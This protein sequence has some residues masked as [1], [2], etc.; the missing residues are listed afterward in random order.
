MKWRLIILSLCF[1][2]IYSVL[3]NANDNNRISP[4]GL[5]PSTVNFYI[6]TSIIKK[7]IKSTAFFIQNFIFK[8]DSHRIHQWVNWFKKQTDCDT[9]DPKSLSK[10]GIDINQSLYIAYENP[11]NKSEKLIIFIPV[12]NEK[13]F[14][15]NFIKMLKKINKDKTD[16]DLNPITTWYKDYKTNQILKDIFF[17]TIDGYFILTSSS[18][19]MRQII[20]IKKDREGDSLLESP[21]YCDY[22]KQNNSP[23]D[24][25]LFIKKEFFIN[26]YINTLKLEK[27]RIDINIVLSEME[28]SYFDLIKYIGCGLKI[29]SGTIDFKVLASINLDCL[30]AKLLMKIFIP[31]KLEKSIFVDNPAA[32]HYLSLNIDTL[33]MLYN[34]LEKSSIQ[35]KSNFNILKQFE[36]FCNIDL[37]EDFI[38]YFDGFFNISIRKPEIQSDMDNFIFFFS[39]KDTSRNNNL[40]E[41]IRVAVKNRYK[42]NNKFGEE[43]IDNIDSFWFNNYRGDKISFFANENDFYISNN[44]EF[45]RVTQNYNDKNIFDL[46]HEYIKK[47]DPQTFLISYIRFDTDS[48]MKNFLLVMAFKIKPQLYNIIKTSDDLFLIGKKIDKYFTFDC[49]M[50]ISPVIE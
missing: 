42:N 27:N 2:S 7:S 26:S 40:W 4:D 1:I 43:K 32:Y 24:L 23:C 37:K 33:D 13:N 31:G 8:K 41:K 35:K 38:P 9:L 45:L 44:I 49:R 21:L 17:T 3:G 20:D 10:V 14:S 36:N 5:I 47:I 12:K 25:N 50:K 28:D 22:M 30:S 29:E 19:Y 6:K 46:D 39:M 15:L 34:K 48:F 18:K 11:I 16:F